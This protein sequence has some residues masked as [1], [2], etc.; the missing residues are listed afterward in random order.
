[1]VAYAFSPIDLVP[2]FIPV[3]GLLDDLLIVPLGI[4]LTLKLVPEAVTVNATPCLTFRPRYACA[5]SAI[6][7]SG[8]SKFAVTF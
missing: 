4:A 5:S 8:M 1:M 3:L 6:N 2:D 7:A